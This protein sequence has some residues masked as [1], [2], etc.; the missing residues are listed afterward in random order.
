VRGGAPLQLEGR[1]ENISGTGVLMRVP[2]GHAVQP[3]ALGRVTLALEPGPEEPLVLEPVAVAR[4]VKKGDDTLIAVD[5]AQLERDVR[6]TI[7][8]FV[9]EQL[10]HV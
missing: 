8:E 10:R 9:L 1:T 2:G 6:S 4:V 5:Y 7:V 3:G